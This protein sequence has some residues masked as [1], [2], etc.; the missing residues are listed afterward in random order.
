MNKK[1]ERINDNEKGQHKEEKKEKRM[2][3]IR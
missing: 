2:E 1:N 3:E